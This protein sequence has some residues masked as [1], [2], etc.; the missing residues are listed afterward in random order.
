[1][2][3]IFSNHNETAAPDWFIDQPAPPAKFA[4]TQVDA[5]RIAALPAELNDSDFDKELDTIS[6]C[7]SAGSPYFYNPQWDAEKTGQLKEY[8]MAYNV[9]AIAASP[10]DPLIQTAKTQPAE[11]VKTAGVIKPVAAM[12][13]PD[14]FHLETKGDM[15]HMK[16]A[17]W[18]QP[19]IEAK[20]VAPTIFMN[21][22]AVIRLSGNEDT[23]IHSH[24]KAIPGQN[25]VTNP[26]AIKDLA[27]QEDT[28][29][30]LRQEAKERAESR[31]AARKGQDAELI[32]QAKENPDA[33]MHGSVQKIDAAAVANCRSFGS[34][35]LDEQSDKTEGEQLGDRREARRKDIQRSAF[36]E[37]EWDDLQGTTKAKVS[38][39]LLAA[40]EAQMDKLGIKTASAKPEVKTAAAEQQVKTAALPSVP[41]VGS[42]G[43]A[44]AEMA[45]RAAPGNPPPPMP[46][47]NQPAQAAA[48]AVQCPKCGPVPGKMVPG[49][50]G[51]GSFVCSKCGGAASLPAAPPVQQMLP[52]ASKQEVKTA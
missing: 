43:E 23:R 37:R 25:S 41:S 6:Q 15:G 3:K 29:S 5:D 40:L 51:V 17:D 38:D 2:A 21:S 32:Q 35:H 44:A 52:A 13:I 31:D 39:L 26:N 33:T 19:S 34:L 7:A 8:A 42:L 16:K 30:R 36:D 20:A 11:M 10:G 22:G 50:G 4:G 28:G 49:A 14:P 24:L 9:S 27:A 12:N 47:R 18:Q 45:R 1:M 48:P 46:S